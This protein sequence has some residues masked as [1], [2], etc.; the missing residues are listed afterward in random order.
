MDVRIKTVKVTE[1]Q[2][3]LRNFSPFINPEKSLV[4]KQQGVR[5]TPESVIFVEKDLF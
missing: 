1:R 5:S 2:Y 3:K 4:Y